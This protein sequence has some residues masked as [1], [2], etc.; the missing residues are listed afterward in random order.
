[1][2]LY[3]DATTGGTTTVLS[4]GQMVFSVMFF[5]FCAGRLDEVKYH[6]GEISEVSAVSEVAL[7]ASVALSPF[8]SRPLVSERKQ[9]LAAGRRC[10][11]A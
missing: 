10:L 5:F 11:W 8:E 3:A 7:F 1:M 4:H 9:H 2:N 6:K